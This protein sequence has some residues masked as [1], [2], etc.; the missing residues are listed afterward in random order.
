MSGLGTPAEVRYANHSQDMGMLEIISV[1][2]HSWHLHFLTLRFAAYENPMTSGSELCPVRLSPPRFIRIQP[3]RHVD[4][5]VQR[6][7]N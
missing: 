7:S 3:L 6:A 5:R 1:V 2:Q 4:S